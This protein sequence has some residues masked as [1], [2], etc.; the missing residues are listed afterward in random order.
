M[1]VPVDEGFGLVGYDGEGAF[2]GGLA[3][4]EAARGGGDGGDGGVVGSDPGGVELGGADGD[5][6]GFQL[7]EVIDFFDDVRCGELAVVS[8]VRPLSSRKY[9]GINGNS[10]TP[11]TGTMTSSG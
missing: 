1:N 2:A 3:G 9:E 4:V 8:L 10:P 5:A 6:F 7:G 11:S